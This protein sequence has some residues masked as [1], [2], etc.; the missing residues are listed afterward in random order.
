M[1]AAN[2]AGRL[3]RH[4][5]GARGPLA[6][7]RCC[8]R[9]RRW[10]G[11]PRRRNS[12]TSCCAPSPTAP[13]FGCATWR[14]SSFAQDHDERLSDNKNATALGI[15]QTPR[16]QCAGYPDAVKATTERLKKDSRSVSTIRGL[17]PDRVHH[18]GVGRRGD[19]ETLFEARSSWS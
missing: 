2:R 1:R 4:K 5:P 16:L 8:V 19:R 15:F 10:A 12:A 18:P 11:S 6:A 14:A 17:Q 9:A 13:W 3:W 7:S